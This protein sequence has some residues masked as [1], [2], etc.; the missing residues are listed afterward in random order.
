[1]IE[2]RNLTKRFGKKVA[3]D[4]L[5]I[6]VP[7]GR[8]TGFLG[9]NGAG[10]STTM[11]LLVGLERPTSGTAMINGRPFA[12][13]AA[14][15]AEVGVL[16]DSKSCHP[17]RSPRDHL[18]ILAATHRI[19]ASRVDD[20][21]ELTGLSS[22]ATQRFGKF[23]LG[24][25]QRVG[26]AAALLGDPRVLILDEPVNGLD[27]EGV[28]WIRTLTRQL[29]DD[30][31]TVF[32]SSHLMAEMAQTADHVIVLG[33]GR[34]LA[35]CPMGEFIAR[36]SGAVTRVRSPRAAELAEA[37]AGPD[38]TVTSPEPGT[39]IIQGLDTVAVAEAAA[40]H[41]WILHENTPVQASLETAFIELTGSAVEYA[42]QPLSSR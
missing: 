5:T 2:T 22:V 11:R 16:L 37:L 31:R 33:Q 18:R 3:V 19:P 32:F 13:A 24:M 40:R 1:M 21:L 26:V 7:P 17:G 27:P 23:S 28:L 42:G 12:S 20:V 8:V 39:L 35:D 6:T 4:D 9:P 14:P 30:G 10:K 34:L 36:A 25:A 41:G 15:L 38:V 29:A